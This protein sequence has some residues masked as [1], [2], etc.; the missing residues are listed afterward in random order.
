MNKGY[1]EIYKIIAFLTLLVGLFLGIVLGNTFTTNVEDEYN[2]L[3]ESFNT[4]LMF[5]I[6]VF[7]SLQVLSYLVFILLVLD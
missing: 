4:L 7:H 3:I 1:I 6:W 5:E 2:N